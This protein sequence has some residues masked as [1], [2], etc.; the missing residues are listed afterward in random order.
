M[1][2]LVNE[3]LL[4]VIKSF[5]AFGEEAFVPVTIDLVLEYANFF[6]NTFYFLVFSLLNTKMKTSDRWVRYLPPWKFI[7]VLGTS[8][9]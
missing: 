4:N 7:F 6:K 5:S 1:V 8:C 9:G 3:K 2:S